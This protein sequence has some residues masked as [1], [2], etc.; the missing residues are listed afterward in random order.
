M[1]EQVVITGAGAITPLGL[2]AA[3]SLGAVWEGRSGISRLTDPQLSDLPIQIGGEVQGFTPDSII[4]VGEARRLDQ[5]ALYAISAG[6][7]ALEQAVPGWRKHRHMPWKEY[8]L[9]VSVGTSAGPVALIQEAT[10]T[11]ASRGPSRVGPGVVV[12]GGAD[13]AASSMATLI[14]ATGPTVGIS[15]TCASGTVALG[16]ALRN[17]RHGYLDAVLVVGADHC[18]T[19]V[20]LA[21]NAN[22]RALTRDYGNEPQR[23]SRP[24]DRDRSGFVM[25]SG[26]AAMLLETKRSAEARGATPLGN[27]LGYGASSDAHHATAPHPEGAGALAAMQF[28][29]TDA[30]LSPEDVDHVNAHATATPRG[31]ASEVRALQRLFPGEIPPITAPK[32]VTGHLLGAAGVFEA[33]VACE[34]IRKGSIPPTLNLQHPEWD[35]DIV[36]GHAR[37]Q[38]VRVVL[39]NSFGFGGHNASIV[40]G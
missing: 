22:I 23:A 21:A 6:L 18:L 10:L 38:E 11:L 9:G 40:L 29:L 37:K 28:A 39:S 25:S 32:S 27:I 17:I 5:H 19:P 3:D 24:F 20:N 15:A 7:E 12:H 4:S 31:D 36:T 35:I 8:R 30:T 33:L 16:E 26:A 2:N 14:G 1:S 13:S 34:T